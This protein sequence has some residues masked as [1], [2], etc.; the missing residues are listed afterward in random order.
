MKMTDF[1]LTQ[2]RLRPISPFSYVGQ[3]RKGAK[4]KTTTADEPAVVPQTR[5]YGGQARI[6]AEGAS[7]RGTVITQD[8]RRVFRGNTFSVGPSALSTFL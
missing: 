5:D 3:G 1:Y 4:V 7:R 8:R 2:S 6:Y